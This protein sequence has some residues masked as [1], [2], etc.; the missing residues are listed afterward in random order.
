MRLH[1]ERHTLSHSVTVLYWPALRISL[2]HLDGSRLVIAESTLGLDV[3]E[4]IF[5]IVA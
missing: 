5:S 3:L 4:S 1:L 2:S